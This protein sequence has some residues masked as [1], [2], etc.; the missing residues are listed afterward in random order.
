MTR[1]ETETE[2]RANSPRIVRTVSDLRTIVECWKADGHSVGLVPTM[3]ALHHGHLSLVHLLA[4]HVDHVVV[5]IFV[6]PAQFG[7]G[8]DLARYPRQ[9]AKDVAA[10]ANSAADLVFAPDV[11]EVYPHGFSSSVHITGL[12][13]DLEGASRPGHFDGM[14]TV[15]MKLLLQS[16]CDTAIFGEKDYQQLAVIRRMAE[17][18][19]LP[20]KIVAAPIV[21][22][23]DG[24][25]ASSRNAYLDHAQR[26]V[27]VGL[28]RILVDLVSR[29]EA[30]E[31]LASLEQKGRKALL[32]AGFDSVDYVCFRDAATLAPI[33]N[34]RQPARLLAVA[35]L[36]TIR[37]LDNMAVAATVTDR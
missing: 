35:R 30:G 26:Q 36:G 11:E 23:D 14:A 17:D 7:P 4:R 19:N 20:V 10:L 21:R 13:E 12:T 37:L 31:D 34:L 27:A 1:S 2:A 3:G 33:R 28:N 16:Q 22:E 9:E 29:A 32:A 18:F 15:V 8:E 24:L 25:A 6:N 5:S